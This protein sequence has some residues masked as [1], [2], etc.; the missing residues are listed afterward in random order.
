MKKIKF[1]TNSHEQA[2]EKTVNFFKKKKEVSAITLVGSVLRGHGSYDADIDID[3]FVSHKKIEKKLTDEFTPHKH[4][5]V[6]QLRQRGDTGK[7]F[8]I[9]FHVLTLPDDL[10]VTPRTWTSGPDMFEVNIAH[11]FVYCD[12]VFEQNKL[13]ADTR[14]KYV[15]YHDELLR[16]QRL[17]DTVKYCLNNIDHIEPYVKRGLYIHALKRMRHA[18]EE[19]IQALFISRRIYPIDYDKW[20]KYELEKILKMPQLYH[21]LIPLYG[22]CDLES[23]ELITK[24]RKLKKLL[25]FHIQKNN[26][27]NTN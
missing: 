15:P 11:Y 21:K 22:L 23:N 2:F 18:T 26:L 8:D 7:F 17:D 3:I 6:E 24:G 1:P 16:Q 10:K 14:K 20:V 25:E 9:G 12:V 5:I 19:F 4:K 27:T 13:Y